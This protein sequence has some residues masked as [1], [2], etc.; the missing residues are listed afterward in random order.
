[1][2]K[3][4]EQGIGTQVH[5]IPI[6]LHPYYSSKGLKLSS[7]PKMERYYH[8]ALSIPLYFELSDELVDRVCTKILEFS[9]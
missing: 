5:Y 4:F 8:E 3:L 6:P 7:F 2:N 9:K 1:M